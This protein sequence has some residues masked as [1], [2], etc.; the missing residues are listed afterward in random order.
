MLILWVVLE[1]GKRRP[2]GVVN[3]KFPLMIYRKNPTLGVV[4]I[5][6]RTKCS[7][8]EKKT[9]IMPR[10]EHS[11]LIASCKGTMEHRSGN[12]TTYEEHAL[13]DFIQQDKDSPFNLVFRKMLN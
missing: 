4:P 2:V 9:C 6:Y 3:V 13:R 7:R 8:K 1:M 10:L 11:D 12:R 5:I